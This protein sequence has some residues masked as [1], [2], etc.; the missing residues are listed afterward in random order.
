MQNPGPSLGRSAQY[1]AIK[2][3]GA[4]TRTVHLLFLSGHTESIAD[5]QAH[6]ESAYLSGERNAQDVLGRD[7][8]RVSVVLTL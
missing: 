4:F 3:T 2:L 7:K 6:S 1:Q 8:A 5:L